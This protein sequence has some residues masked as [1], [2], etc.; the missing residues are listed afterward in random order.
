MIEITL[1]FL[2]TKDLPHYDPIVIAA[3]LVS[4]FLHRARDGR[5]ITKVI[6]IGILHE[7]RF[8]S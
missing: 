1:P 4:L 8:E 6:W 2:T 5:Y 3:G 7:G